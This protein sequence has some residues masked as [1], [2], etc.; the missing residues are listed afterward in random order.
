MNNI[1]SLLPNAAG[2]F[3]RSFS[4]SISQWSGIILAT[5][6]SA[7]A[8][9]GIYRWSQASKSEP[10]VVELPDL[11]QVKAR[12]AKTYGYVFGG[13]ALTAATAAASHAVGLSRKILENGYLHIPVTILTIGALVKTIV[14][15][16]KEVKTKH[17][18]LAVFNAGMGISLSPLGFLPRAVIAQAA[19]ITLGIGSLLTFAAHMAP[20]K[21]FLQWEGPL[22][23]ALTTL[24]IASL[25]ACFFPGTA[26]A[27]GMDRASLYG[28]LLIFSG[29]F[30]VSTQQLVDEAKNQ[31]D[32]VFDPINSSLN[33]YHDTLNMFIRLLRIFLE[34]QKKEN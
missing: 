20:D 2:A 8:G 16:K 6:F 22:M 3:S 18:A 25:V 21:Q 1:S 29:F 14:T 24:S 17:I 4:T 32:T 26:Y 12:V 27:Y 5:S 33:L 23:V 28:G 9:L 15:D 7:L 10:T 19:F 13:L 11:E 31:E 30:L 34:N